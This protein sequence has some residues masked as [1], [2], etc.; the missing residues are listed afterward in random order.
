MKNLQCLSNVLGFLVACAV[1]Y[2]QSNRIFY[3]P[4]IVYCYIYGHCVCA[5]FNLS[6]ICM[7]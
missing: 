3:T 7:Y 2:I 4:V 1:G 6:F 5:L